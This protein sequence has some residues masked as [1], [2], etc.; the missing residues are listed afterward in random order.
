MAN[1]ERQSWTAEEDAAIATLVE[2]LGDN[3][4]WSV[5]SKL[6]VERFGVRKRSGK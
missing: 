3:K 5:I 4:L 1:R 6:M 2:E